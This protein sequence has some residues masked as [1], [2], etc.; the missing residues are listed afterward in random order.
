MGDGICSKVKG[1]T[2]VNVGRSNREE[3]SYPAGTQRMTQ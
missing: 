3:R 1:K 2:I